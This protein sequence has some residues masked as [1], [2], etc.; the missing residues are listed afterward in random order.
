MRQ[1]EVGRTRQES[2]ASSPAGR[3]RDCTTS[4]ST[5]PALPQDSP[6][7]SGA[8]RSR[9]KMSDA[10][11]AE[12]CTAGGGAPTRRRPAAGVA[13]VWPRRRAAPAAVW[14]P[15]PAR[16][17]PTLEPARSRGLSPRPQPR[18]PGRATREQS[19]SLQA[20]EARGPPPCV[21]GHRSQSSPQLILDLG[22]QTARR[23]YLDCK[24]Q[25]VRRAYQ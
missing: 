13:R 22:L 8:P 6:D 15:T 3:P 24:L 5:S 10:R 23:D 9:S 17:P 19:A 7:V 2:A 11:A 1:A 16:A 25:S 21:S 4:T 20:H 18:Q 14:D 12:V